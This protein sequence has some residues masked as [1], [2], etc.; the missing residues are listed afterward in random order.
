MW[1][2]GFKQILD[3]LS[4]VYDLQDEMLQS[5]VE[6]TCATPVTELMHCKMQASLFGAILT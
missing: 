3:D 2:L 4:T 6:N 1:A 5:E